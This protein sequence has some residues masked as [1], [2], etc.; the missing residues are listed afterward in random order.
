MGV[1]ARGKM[2]DRCSMASC[3]YC[4][5][6]RAGRTYPS[7]FRHTKPAIDDSSI[8][9]TVERSDKY[10]RHWPMTYESEA[11]W[12]WRNALLTAPL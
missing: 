5:R 9:L 7:D 6:V 11:N 10:W 3:G 12:T 8:G 2:I 4:D 1:V